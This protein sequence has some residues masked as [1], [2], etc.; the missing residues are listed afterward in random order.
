MRNFR[1]YAIWILSAYIAFVFVQSL[2]FKFTGAPESIHHL[3]H[4]AGMVRTSLS[5][6]LRAGGLSAQLS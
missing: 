3:L 1:P 2:F 4:F 6:N 5:L